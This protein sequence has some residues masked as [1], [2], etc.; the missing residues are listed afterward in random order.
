MLNFSIANNFIIK[1][2]ITAIFTILIT[3]C[4]DDNA[5]NSA[6]LN[7][8]IA[9][10]NALNNSPTNTQSKNNQVTSQATTV[11]VLPEGITR[12]DFKITDSKNIQTLR[13]LPVGPQTQTI[14]L[15]VAAHRDLV[16]V[17]E[18]LSDDTVSFRG[19]TNVSA[20]SPGQSFPLSVSLDEIGVPTDT[21]TL[22]LSQ[23]AISTFEGDT[24]T[25]NLTFNV[26]LSALANGNVTASY[27]TSDLTAN[28]D[29]DYVTSDSM[30]T[31]P[32]GQLSTTISV[33]VSGDKTPE[34]DETFTLTLSNASANV[35][36][37]NTSATGI[38][39]SD[40]YLG[41]LNDTG[42]TLCGD[43][44][45]SLIES[46]TGTSSNN[47]YR[48][49]S[50][51][52]SQTE[53]GF[54][55]DDDPVPAAQ[56][57][58]Y[59]R[60]ATNNDD[61]DGLAGF[62]FT[63]LD[64]DGFRLSDQS[65]EFATQSW[66]CVKDQY[67]GLTWEV[68]LPSGSNNF[69]DTDYTYTWLNTTGVNDGGFA[70]ANSD[71][72]CD[73]QGSGCNTEAYVNDI[74]SMNL[75]GASNWRL[76]TVTELMSIVNNGQTSPAIDINYFPHTQI[77]NSYWTSTP[78]SN[79]NSASWTW[80]VNFDTGMTISGVKTESESIRLVHDDLIPL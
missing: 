44:S 52:T 33:Q 51:G 25:E 12:V 41:R 7:V 26:S 63:K 65:Q 19:Q 16:I 15:R 72:G 43:Y 38:I 23:S 2:T 30:L 68:K 53:S 3:A 66:A 13:S 5:D 42:V 32:A 80:N 21:V 54:D 48:C 4:N 8:S 57:A 11:N 58:H 59:G 20:L 18:A 10:S 31:I 62:S 78:Q 36:L 73:I 1:I 69:Q 46:N 14:S 67:T 24:G 29:S 61:S 47:S 64:G 40:D 71:I 37:G 74:N 50:S 79:L 17:I 28:F 9:G 22:S 77:N 56:D 6:Y 60:D 49:A 34:D 75:C 55:F 45:A 76:P 35:T 39:I 27:S 70:G